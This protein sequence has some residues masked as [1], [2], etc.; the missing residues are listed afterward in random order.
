MYASRYVY[1][2]KYVGMHVG[3]HVGIYVGVRYVGKVCICDFQPTLKSQMHV[4]MCV[5][6]VM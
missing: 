4:G 3:M 1:R 2:C 6:V 5:C